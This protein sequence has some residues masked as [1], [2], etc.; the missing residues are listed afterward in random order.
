MIP[1]KKKK[2]FLYNSSGK[3]ENNE[4]DQTVDLNLYFNNNDYPNKFD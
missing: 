3:A 2:I 4:N 1:L